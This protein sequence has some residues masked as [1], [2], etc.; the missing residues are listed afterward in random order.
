MRK[1]LVCVGGLGN[2]LFIWNA[3]HQTITRGFKVTVLINKRADRR[4]ELNEF[5]EVCSH[6]IKVKDTVIL[7]KIFNVLDAFIWKFP[8]FKDLYSSIGVVAYSHPNDPIYLESRRY[9]M[10]RGYF[11]SLEM[12]LE[13]K[14]VVLNEIMKV[15]NNNLMSFKSRNPLSDIYEAFHIRRGDLKQNL[16]SIGVLSD[17]F[18]KDLRTTLPL[19]ITTEKRSDLTNDFGAATIASEENSSNWES[20]ALLCFAN[21]LVTANSTF[22]WW[23]GMVAK[24]R[25]PETIVIQPSKYYKNT[26]EQDFLKVNEFLLLKSRF[27]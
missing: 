4:C 14:E 3:A 21:R 11:Q 23:A 22:S 27:L 20:F 15:V 5:K 19:V 12:V 24:F 17:D 18:Y 26:S 1:Y 16:E 6:D 9:F 8:R 13:Q 10:H 2:Q 25:D 7:F